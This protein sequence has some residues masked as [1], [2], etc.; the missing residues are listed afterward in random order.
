MPGVVG[1]RCNS[2]PVEDIVCLMFGHVFR[3]GH[4]FCYHFS[5][6]FVRLKCCFSAP[7][8]G[9]FA[10]GLTRADD[11]NEF[12]VLLLFMSKD[13]LSN[14]LFF[15]KFIN[16]F[17]QNTIIF[18]TFLQDPVSKFLS[19][20]F[21]EKLNWIYYKYNITIVKCLYNTYIVTW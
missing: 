13:I 21:F 16:F 7:P 19:F 15:R 1:F 18:Y 10:N 3:L 4:A 20:F 6:T 2:K 11:I 12:I 8:S 17:F 9:L 14:L 5:C